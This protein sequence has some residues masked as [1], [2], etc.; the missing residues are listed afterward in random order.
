MGSKEKK[1]KCFNLGFLK[2]NV[3][4][5]LTT[6][7]VL[8]LPLLR[9]RAAYP[10]GGFEIVTYKPIF[11]L[12]SYLHMNDWYPFFLMI[13][14]TLFIYVATSALLSIILWLV[15]KKRYVFTGLIVM[16]IGLLLFKILNVPDNDNFKAPGKDWVSEKK[17]EDYFI[18]KLRMTPEEASEI[19]NKPGVDGTVDLRISTNTTLEGLVGNLYYYGFIRHKDT[20][21]YALENTKDNTPNDKSIRVG[22]EG[23]IDINAEYRISENMTAWQIADILLNKP[24]GHYSL[25][26][27]NYF[28]MP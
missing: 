19:R 6:H 14:F 5:V 17:V 9:E 24:E 13:G 8:S 27:Y 26:E 3:L 2:P 7:I 11:L 1:L 20:F 25:D 21:L 18:E 10:E 12:V 15:K 16:A 4:N 28:F 22:K 23:T